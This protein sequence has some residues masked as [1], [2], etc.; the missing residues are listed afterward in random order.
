MPSDDYAQRASAY[1][2]QC[3]KEQ[4]SSGGIIECQIEGIPAGIGEPVFHKLD[5]ALAQAVMSIGAVKGV[6]IGDGFRSALAK[7]SDNMMLLLLMVPVS[8]KGPT[9]PAAP[10]A[11]KRRQHPDLP[12]RRQTHAIYCTPAAHRN[13]RWKRNRTFHTRKTRSCHRSPGRRCCG[14]HGCPGTC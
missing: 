10:W 14:G 6:E 13:L 3:I 11:L 12:R 8:G 7:G 2:E 9:T 1:L 4:D 5:A